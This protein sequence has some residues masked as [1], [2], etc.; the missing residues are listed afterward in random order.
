[1]AFEYGNITIPDDLFQGVNGGSADREATLA[2]LG[3]AVNTT[4]RDVQRLNQIREEYQAEQQRLDAERAVYAEA[5]VQGKLDTAAAAYAEKV[6]KFSREIV[7][8]V[9]FIRDNIA[10]VTRSQPFDVADAG[11]Q[12]VLATITASGENLPLSAQLQFVKRYEANRAALAL[13]RGVYKNYG[14][15]S[16]PVEDAFREADKTINTQPLEN[17]LEAAVFAD[18][19]GEWKP[20]FVAD[21][22][23]V[24]NF[25]LKYGLNITENPYITELEQAAAKVE[26]APRMAGAD[27]ATGYTAPTIR[28]IVRQAVADIKAVEKDD[29]EAVQRIYQEAML[30]ISTQG[31]AKQA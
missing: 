28:E 6:K 5:V 10:T 7:G 3:R 21:V 1:M 25:A 9:S 16:Q 26:D 8:A 12:A 30:K 15:T 2:D 11:F 31:R 22:R 17:I 14:Y 24:Y 29:P 4:L 13:L 27:G 23:A 18:Y 20:P 19:R